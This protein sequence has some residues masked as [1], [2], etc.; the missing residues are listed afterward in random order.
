M[1][2]NEKRGPGQPPLPDELKRFNLAIRV[3]LEERKKLD[4]LAKRAGLPV[5]TYIRKK[6]LEEI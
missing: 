1:A 5:T 4:R 3:S 2:E 6:A